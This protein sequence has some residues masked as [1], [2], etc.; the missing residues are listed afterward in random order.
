VA[1][2]GAVPRWT[3]DLAGA[4]VQRQ[5]PALAGAWEDPIIPDN[6]GQ[7][8]GQVLHS[9]TCLLEVRGPLQSGAALRRRTAR[10]TVE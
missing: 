1:H 10:L 9:S 6:R 5:E 2:G 4:G 8:W 7:Q 3:I